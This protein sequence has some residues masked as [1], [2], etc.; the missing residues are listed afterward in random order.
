METPILFQIFKWDAV[1][2]GRNG[3]W[4][5]HVLTRVQDLAEAKITMAWF[6][7]CQKC[8]GQDWV[9]YSWMDAYDLGEHRQ[10]IQ[11]WDDQ[12]KM[13][14]H[15]HDVE[16]SLDAGDPLQPRKGTETLYGHRSELDQLIAAFKAKG[17]VSLADIVINHRDAQQ[18]NEHGE[19]I[20]WGSDEHSIASGKMVWGYK[21][22][23]EDPEEVEWRAGGAGYDDG[24]GGFA[25]NIAH[26]STKARKDIKDWLLWMKDTVGF[27]GW[28]YD[29]VKGFAPERIAEYNYHTGN[30]I[31]IGE[32]RDGEPQKI[33]DWID[34]TD[35][36]SVERRSLAFDFPLQHHLRSIF[37]GTKP[38]EQLG[39]W[40]YASVSITGGWPA[41]SVT[42][43][44]NHDMSR[45]AGEDFPT[46]RKRLIQGYVFL[47]TSPGTP[48]IFWNHYFERGTEVHDTIKTLCQFRNSRGIASTSTVGVLRSAP[49]CYAARVDGKVIVKIGDEFWSPYGI[50]GH[51]DLTL[52]GDGWAIWARR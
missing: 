36:Y 48:C 51:W 40:K 43:V 7:P 5:E 16:S 27:G 4:Y 3:D 9:G 29:Y 6:P 12:K 20:C 32:Y 39:L 14:W 31:S 17:I 42:F 49:A 22:K 28:R 44:D 46:D 35:G 33:Y 52:S 45:K 41:K 37:W 11:T 1:H 2:N 26:K 47:L 34:Q 8:R 10:W 23:E 19:F 24:E 25:V 13:S 50:E 30:P 21:G 38:F 18:L 15:Q